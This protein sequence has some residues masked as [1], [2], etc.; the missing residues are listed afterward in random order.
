MIVLAV[1]SSGEKT[2]ILVSYS[3]KRIVKAGRPIKALLGKMVKK[4]PRR[5]VL[6][7]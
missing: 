5:K 6:S 3:P 2:P 7:W 1:F 4:L